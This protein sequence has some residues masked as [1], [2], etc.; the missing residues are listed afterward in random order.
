MVYM[1]I[2]QKFGDKTFSS[3]KIRNYRLYFIGQGI[4]LA[5]TWMQTVAQA[6]L[7]LQISHS[8]TTLGIVSALQFLP[9]L[10]FGPM[11]GVLVDRFSKKTIL[12]YTQAVSAVLALALGILVAMGHIQLWEVYVLA[13]LLGLVGALDNPAR[14][15]FILE[16]VGENELSN[17][18]TLSTAELNLAR[19]AG[20][21]LAG[22]LIATVGL[23]V[24]FIL[25]AVSYIAVIF[26]FFKMHDKEIHAFAA[27][28][29]LKGQL[30]EGFRYVL[31]TPYLRD[32]LIIMAIIGTFTYEF[33][34]N[35]PLF[36]QFTLH[37]D[38]GTYAILTAFMGMGAVIGGLYTAHRAQATERMLVNT[39]FFLGLSTLLTSLMPTALF[40]FAS[41]AIVGY[42]S[43]NFISQ[44]NI[45]LQLKSIPEM[46]GRVMALWTVAF[47]GSTVIGAPIIGWIGETFSPRWGL[48][49]SG[50]AAIIAA[51]Y[52]MLKMR[53][54]TQQQIPKQIMIESEEAQLTEE[55]ETRAI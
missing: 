24:C 55:K 47:L 30:S 18:V 15:T 6:W 23:S 14:Q 26:V 19:V 27:T 49:V 22:A 52:G 54:T 39:A 41:L 32:A 8:G 36:T 45:L 44:S 48:G 35:L 46:R 13:L 31:S 28:K 11:A 34:V 7:V 51:G 10:L 2:F 29:K 5:G 9:I 20:P 40:A 16:M 33:A 38:A 43:V 50:L 21:A 12:Y 4:S 17:A 42:C 25:N 53:G 1:N 37:G 3:L